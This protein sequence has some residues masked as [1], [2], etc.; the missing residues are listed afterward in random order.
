MTALPL[1]SSARSANKDADGLASSAKP[2]S[3]MVKIPVSDVDPKR[4]LIARN[5]RN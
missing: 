5:M 3:I 4:F 1:S 2:S